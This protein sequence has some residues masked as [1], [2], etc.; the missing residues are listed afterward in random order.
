MR[1][2]TLP[3][4]ELNNKL[5]ICCL[6]RRLCS[7]CAPNTSGSCP[8]ARPPPSTGPEARAMWLSGSSKRWPLIW[9]VAD[10]WH[11]LLATPRKKLSP[12]EPCAARA[13]R[14]QDRRVLVV[15]SLVSSV[16]VR[17]RS[18]AFKIDVAAQVVDLTVFSELLSQLLKIGRTMVRPHP[19][20]VFDLRKGIFLIFFA[21][22]LSFRPRIFLAA[23]SR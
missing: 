5:T 1:L 4:D 11:G 19:A 2:S 6:R 22:R 3:I 18:L 23:P 13:A 9:P 15:S 16:Y 21:L 10:Q 7:G 20:T 14:A 8:S 12:A 17:L